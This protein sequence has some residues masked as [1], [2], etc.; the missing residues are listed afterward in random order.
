MPEMPD[1]PA[2]ATEFPSERMTVDENIVF[3]STFQVPAF[4]F[5]ASDESGSPLSLPALIRS[6]LFHLPLPLS[7]LNIEQHTI[8]LPGPESDASPIP[9]LTQGEH[10]TTGRM[11]WFLH[12]CETSGA[13]KELLDHG[14][15]PGERWE[16]HWLKTWF[17][18]LG[19]VVYLRGIS[20]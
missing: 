10:P 18:V 12:P 2:A 7:T 15:P 1:D 11:C 16:L 9:L 3:S 17:V 5:S 20:V 19:R 13:V 4:Y 6:Q 14:A 8:D